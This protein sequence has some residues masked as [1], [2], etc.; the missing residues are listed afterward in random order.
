MDD[1]EENNMKNLKVFTGL[2]LLTAVA[3][4]KLLVVAIIMG[5]MLLSKRLVLSRQFQLRLLKRVEK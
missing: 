4:T 3:L 2:G 5:L 1:D